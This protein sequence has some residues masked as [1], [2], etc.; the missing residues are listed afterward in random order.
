[1]ENTYELDRPSSRTK[2]LIDLVLIAELAALDAAALRVAIE[3]TF[4]VRGTHPV[5]EVLPPPPQEWAT[6]FREL[7][8]TVGVPAGPSAA[9]AVATDLMDCILDGVVHDGTWDPEKRVWT[10]DG[11]EL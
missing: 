7:A 9:H 3:T 4:T 2:D 8:S 11:Y 1:M 5:P 10:R 6:R